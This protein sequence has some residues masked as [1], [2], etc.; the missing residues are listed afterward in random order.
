MIIKKRG[1]IPACDSFVVKRISGP[2]LA[3]DYFYQIKPEQA[4][5]SLEAR[6]ELDEL[7]AYQHEMEQIIMQPQKDFSQFVECCFAPFS[8]QLSKTGVYSVLEKEG[9]DLLSCL[10]EKLERRRRELQTGLST[11]I[12]SKIRL[13]TMHL[14]VSF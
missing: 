11:T 13:S 6:M 8:A 12:R 2:G 9:Q 10:H 3:N 7:S 4:L 1:R 14:K 5:A